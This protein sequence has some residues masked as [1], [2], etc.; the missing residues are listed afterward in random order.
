MAAQVAVFQREM[1]WVDRRAERAY[2][3]NDS[4]RYASSGPFFPP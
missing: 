1:S 4:N 2:L 3:P